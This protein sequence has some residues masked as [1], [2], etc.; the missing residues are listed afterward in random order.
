V[1]MCRE[2]KVA[3]AY[4]VNTRQRYIGHARTTPGC[5]MAF[6]D[7]ARQLYNRIVISYS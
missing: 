3:S 2:L 1:Y 4:W 7:C 6:G 5:N